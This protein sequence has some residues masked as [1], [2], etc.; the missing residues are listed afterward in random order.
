MTSNP[1]HFNHWLPCQIVRLLVIEWNAVLS[2]RPHGSVK[3]WVGRMHKI[4]VS[5]LPSFHAHTFTSKTVFIQLIAPSGSYLFAAAVDRE[6]PALDPIF[7]HNA[8]IFIFSP[9]YCCSQA[10]GC[11]GAHEK[12]ACYLRERISPSGKDSTNIIYP[13]SCTA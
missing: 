6:S 10:L 3:S 12:Y 13:Y 5:L 11:G 7:Y 2:S 1:L 4:Y 8:F 9:R